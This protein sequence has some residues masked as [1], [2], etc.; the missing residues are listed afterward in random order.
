M[1]PYVFVMFSVVDRTNGTAHN[2][3]GRFL[4]IQNFGENMA[5]LSVDWN[6][7]NEALDWKEGKRVWEQMSRIHAQMPDMRK[8]METMQVTL[9]YD[10]NFVAQHGLE[11]KRII[12]WARECFSLAFSSESTRHQFLLRFD[13]P[14][15]VMEVIFGTGTPVADTL[16]SH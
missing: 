7:L 16:W 14:G 8:L 3:L 2:S 1:K 13:Q 15:N 11:M 9:L 10:M 6:E 4:P 5:K 12:A